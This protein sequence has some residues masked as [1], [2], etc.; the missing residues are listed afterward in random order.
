MCIKYLKKNKL[1]FTLV[2]LLVGIAI[3]AVLATV[4]LPSINRFVVSMRV[5]NEIA[6]LH[7][8]LLIAR[9]T[10]VNSGQDVVVCPIVSGTC[11]DDWTKEITVFIDFDQDNDFDSVAGVTPADEII[12]I[13]S[14]T[15]NSSD[16]FEYSNG[17]SITYN[18]LGNLPSNNTESTFSYCP[19]GY[20]DE[21]RGIIVAVSGRAYTSEDS[22]GDGADED[23]NNNNITCS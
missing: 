10:S 8:L 4:A 19:H 7:R 5:D 18:S 12:R 11:T 16:Q 17:A 20:T 21:S 3:V 1:G 23:R 9:N 15:S 22:D 6:E 14:A 13:K 2:E